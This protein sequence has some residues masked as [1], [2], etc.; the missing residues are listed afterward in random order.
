MTTLAPEPGA[1]ADTMPTSIVAAV[2]A[3]ANAGLRNLL[4]IALVW[5]N[6][7]SVA[8]LQLYIPWLFLPPSYKVFEMQRAIR[9]S[10]AK[11]RR[12]AYARCGSG[13]RLASAG[14]WH[15]RGGGVLDWLKG[16]FNWVKDNHIISK[17]LSLIPNP[18]GQASSIA[19]KVVGLGR[20][21]R[22]RLRCRSATGFALVQA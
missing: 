22:L 19:A 12:L 3:P 21:R 15:G 5:R 4:P 10:A 20:R 6:V 2:P 13:R 7:A 9:T 17:G 18:V 8:P 1:N 11:H 16:A 14:R